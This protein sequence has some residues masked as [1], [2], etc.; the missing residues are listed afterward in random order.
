MPGCSDLPVP[1]DRWNGT[2]NR[3]CRED[4]K[5]YTFLSLSSLFITRPTRRSASL[6]S[7]FE[8]WQNMARYKSSRSR[9]ILHSRP[10]ISLQRKNWILVLKGIPDLV[11]FA[12]S[13]RWRRRSYRFSNLHDISE[14]WSSRPMPRSLHWKYI[15]IQF[16]APFLVGVFRSRFFFP[17]HFSISDLLLALWDIYGFGVSWQLGRNSKSFETYFEVNFNCT[18]CILTVGLKIRQDKIALSFFGSSPPFLAR[19]W[20]F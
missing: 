20:K 18:C 11:V 1:N 15:R 13:R 6:V 10:S 4:I 3:G 8:Y 7:R 2:E 19:I 5:I 16:G 17:L 9:R 14:S 12:F